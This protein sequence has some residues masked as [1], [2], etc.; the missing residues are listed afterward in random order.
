[1]QG[2]PEVI[3]KGQTL[4]PLYQAERLNL[5]DFFPVE[6]KTDKTVPII[7]VAKKVALSLNRANKIV[8][9]IAATEFTSLA[10]DEERP[11]NIP[12]FGGVPIIL[13]R[14]KNEKTIKVLPWINTKKAKKKPVI[15]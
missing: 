9:H 15:I 4:Q 10:P 2:Q 6:K 12:V 1:M 5:P 14:D 13:W 8:K 7:Y 11:M 3:K